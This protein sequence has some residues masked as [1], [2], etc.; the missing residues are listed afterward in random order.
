MSAYTP[1]YKNNLFA[2]NYLSLFTD[3][4]QH[5]T[6]ITLEEYKDN[7]CLY[8]VDLTQDYSASDPFMNVA[9]SGDISIHLKFGEDIPETVTLLVDMK[10]QSLI[11]IDKIRNIFTDY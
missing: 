10:M 5:N 9:R 4:A 6:N 7:T 1:S 3:V 2:R 8:V 11:E